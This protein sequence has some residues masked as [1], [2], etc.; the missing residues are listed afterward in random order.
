MYLFNRFKLPWTCGGGYTISI[1][2]GDSQVPPNLRHSRT[3]GICQ[4]LLES[5]TEFVV[6]ER[7]DKD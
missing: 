2:N 6:L 3:N 4:A 5:R 7:F 1:I